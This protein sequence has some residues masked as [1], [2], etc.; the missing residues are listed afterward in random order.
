MHPKET[1]AES[2]SSLSRLFESLKSGT[3]ASRG[4]DDAR[5][6]VSIKKLAFR[7][8]FQSPLPQTWS[9]QER[10]RQDG[11]D[12]TLDGHGFSLQDADENTRFPYYIV[13][14]ASDPKP[15]G[16][17]FLLH[18][19]NE[20]SWDKYLPWAAALCRRTGKGVILFPIAFHMDRVPR[21]WTDRRILMRLASLRKERYPGIT[22]VSFINAALSSRLHEFRQVPPLRVANLS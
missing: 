15:R 21:S 6:D 16:A 5:S 20:K 11:R 14:P 9:G 10:A 1:Y 2:L 8:D 12:S 4:V 22:E 3:A 13:L 19:L 17:I 18:G 7:S